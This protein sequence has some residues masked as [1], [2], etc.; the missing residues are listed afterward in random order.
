MGGVLIPRYKRF[1]IRQK[2]RLR[3]GN[4]DMVGDMVC[5][6]MIE[7]SLEACRIGGYGH[8]A[9]RFDQVVTVEVEGFGDVTGTVRSVGERC[10]AIRFVQ[11]LRPAELQELV[12][13]ACDE[14]RPILHLPAFGI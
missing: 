13:S 4:G 12:W 9:F 7:V 3:A 2:V 10:F 11:P 8:D 5:G 6:T 1:A 14:E